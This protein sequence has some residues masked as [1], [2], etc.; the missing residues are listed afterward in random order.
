VQ[1]NTPPAGDAKL[2]N[3]LLDDTNAPPTDA[4]PTLLNMMGACTAH[5]A[6][7]ESSREHSMPRMRKLRIA[8]VGIREMRARA[9]PS[10]GS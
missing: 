6:R 2:V 10:P 4:D 7:T 8:R 3:A 9:I 1:E 5:S